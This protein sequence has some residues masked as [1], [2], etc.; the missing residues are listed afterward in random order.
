MKVA[1][2]PAVRFAEN[3]TRIVAKHWDYEYFGPP[4]FSVAP[5]VKFDK[6]VKTDHDGQRSV[7]AFVDAEARVYKAENWNRPV[8]KP[9]Y[10]DVYV[11]LDAFRRSPGDRRIGNIGYLYADYKPQSGE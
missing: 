4:T 7:H 11:A 3:L 8:K 6:I 1:S 5:G 2:Q 10:E 9:K